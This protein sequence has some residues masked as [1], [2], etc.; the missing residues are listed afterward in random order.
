MMQNK[1]QISLEIDELVI[2]IPACVTMSIKTRA[3]Y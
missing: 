1:L 3:I 2:S